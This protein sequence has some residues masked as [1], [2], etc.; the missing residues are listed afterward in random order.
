MA[1]TS[2]LQCALGVWALRSLVG[3]PSGT[4]RNALSKGRAESD[5]ETAPLVTGTLTSFIAECDV[6]SFLIPGP[7][8]FFTEKR[9]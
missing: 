8:L 9:T 6:T 3:A 7:E 4:V 1:V 5:L 2:F